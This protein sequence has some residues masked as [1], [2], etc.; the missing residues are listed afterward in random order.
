MNSPSPHAYIPLFAC[1]D[2]TF[3]DQFIARRLQA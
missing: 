2:C 1:D 3:V